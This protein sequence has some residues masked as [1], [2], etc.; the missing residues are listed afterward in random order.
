MLSEQLKKNTI[1]YILSQKDVNMN[2]TIVVICQ[3]TYTF[4]NTDVTNEF[5]IPSV[6]KMHLYVVSVSINSIFT[7][8][9][10]VTIPAISR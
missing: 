5:K 6:D 2:T 7:L 3:G 1:T 4:V 9:S 8:Q 10:P